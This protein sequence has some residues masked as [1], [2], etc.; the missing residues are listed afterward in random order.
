MRVL[1][2]GAS[3]FIGR[4][5][6]RHLAGARRHTVAGTFRSRPPA[7]DGN[8]WHRVE[9]SDRVE[10]ERVFRMAR[11][12]AVVHLAAIADVGAAERD[13]QRASAVNVDGT[14]LVA[15]LCQLHQAR[16]VYV[17]TEYVFPGTP[18]YYPEDATPDPTTHYGRTKWEAEQRVAELCS[19]WSVLRTSIVYGWPEPG[20][21]NFGPRLIETLRNGQPY[22]ARTDV[23]R[24]PIYVGHLVESI[25]ALTTG[26]YQGTYHVA[27]KDWVSMYHFAHAIAQAFDLDTDLV[28]PAGSQSKELGV[29]VSG[30]PEQGGASDL[31]GLDSAHTMAVLGLQRYGLADGIRAFRAGAPHF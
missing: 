24:T 25:A 23:Y 30:Q 4:H 31:L 6:V 28:A 29:G 16:L 20:Q 3:G 8:S 11:P 18:G 27:G 21:R 10:L 14:S 15:Q 12:E 9:L 5:L 22:H 1:V 19:R 7:N 13:R 17:S 2:I 26:D